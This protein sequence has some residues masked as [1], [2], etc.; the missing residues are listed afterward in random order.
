MKQDTE[1]LLIPKLI[2][3]EEVILQLDK[4]LIKKGL[5]LAILKSNLCTNYGKMTL[6]VLI[7]SN[8]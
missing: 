5:I 7:I 3:V 2:L 1:L 8:T 6:I 4:K